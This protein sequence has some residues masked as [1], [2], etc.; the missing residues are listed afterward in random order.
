[1]HRASPV[2]ISTHPHTHLISVRASA[3]RLRRPHA[4]EASSTTHRCGCGQPLKSRHCTRYFY[5]VPEA[6]EPVDLRQTVSWK[7]P[8]TT[9]APFES[10]THIH[11]HFGQ[12][13]KGWATCLKQRRT[14]DLEACSASCYAACCSTGCMHQGCNLAGSS[15]SVLW[16][17]MRRKL[18]KTCSSWN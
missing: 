5:G 11:S 4:A 12:T 2:S 17:A 10:H 3:Y 15:T 6:F 13:S 18:S 8:T 7:W 1:M 14:V 16:C 9:C